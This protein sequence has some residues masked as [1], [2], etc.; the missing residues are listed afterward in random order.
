MNLPSA[1]VAMAALGLALATSGLGPKVRRSASVAVPDWG[2]G[3]ADATGS[4]AQQAMS[5]LTRATGMDRSFGAVLH[6]TDAAGAGHIVCPINSL[7][8]TLTNSAVEATA[9]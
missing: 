7:S 9:G 3:G 4:R 8:R 6:D 1:A 2:D 5:L